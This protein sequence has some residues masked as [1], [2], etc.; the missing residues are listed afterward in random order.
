MKRRRPQILVP[1]ASMGDIAILLINFF[2]VVSQ[3]VRDP[4]V[5]VETPRSADIDQ[6]EKNF[7]VVVSITED[8]KIYLNRTV[9][10]DADAIE[11]GVR[12]MIENAEDETQRTV[13]FKCDQSVSQSVFQP[14]WHA[15]IQSGAR[16][17]AVGQS[18]ATEG[19]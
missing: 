10:P 8:G 19:S 17:A 16:I 3:Q 14:V 15:L 12:A 11:W 6:L 13:L 4:Y 9:V 5:Q 2:N 1:Q 7:P 18:P